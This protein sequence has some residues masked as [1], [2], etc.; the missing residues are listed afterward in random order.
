MFKPGF[1]YASTATTEEKDYYFKIGNS[2][3]ILSSLLS[4]PLSLVILLALPR[5]YLM[6]NTNYNL[7]ILLAELIEKLKC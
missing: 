4:H 7:I 5:H 1:S 3:V 2:P 6:L